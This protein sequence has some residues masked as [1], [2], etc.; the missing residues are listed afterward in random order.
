M[1]ADHRAI[2][3]TRFSHAQSGQVQSSRVLAPSNDWQALMPKPDSG[4]QM[5][6]SFIRLGIEHIGSGADHI[7]FVI[8]LVL[9]IALAQSWKTLLITITAFTLGHSI[10]LIAATL[11][12]VGSP[13]WVEPAIAASIAVTAALNL[14]KRTVSWTESVTLKIAVAASFGL[15]HGLGFSGAMQEAQVAPSVLPWALAG[16]NMGVE[17][18]QLA[19][20]GA[21]SLIYFALNSWSGY[22]RWIVQYGSVLLV[23]L[24]SYWFFERLGA[25]A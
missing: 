1:D 24:S 21:W 18:G 10:T 7:A 9:G 12:W 14:F 6:L 23:V 15:V 5:L 3:S 17:I 25:F 13:A 2:L 16:F 11:G 19:I 4:A 20:I 8:C 22:Q